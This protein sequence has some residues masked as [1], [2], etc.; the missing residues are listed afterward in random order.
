MFIKSKITALNPS[1]S[2][3]FIYP[4]LFLVVLYYI[5]LT[6][7]ERALSESCKFH[8]KNLFQRKSCEKQVLDI[9]IFT[10]V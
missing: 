3:W 8:L 10:P 6:G 1:R 9:L 4:V 7:D 2:I 5:S